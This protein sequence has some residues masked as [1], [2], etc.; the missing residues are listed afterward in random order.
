MSFSWFC[1]QFEGILYVIETCFWD[2]LDKKHPKFSEEFFQIFSEKVDEF[3]G[4][5]KTYGAPQ[6]VFT[7]LRPTALTKH[8][9]EGGIRGLDD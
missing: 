9:S 8:L 4:E 6:R 5:W 3:N 1:D 2:N 7:D